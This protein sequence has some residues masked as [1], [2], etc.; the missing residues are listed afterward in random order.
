M[1]TP[2]LLTTGAKKTTDHKHINLTPSF[3][4]SAAILKRYALFRDDAALTSQKRA[5]L[6]PFMFTATE[7]N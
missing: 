5:Y 7:V 3:Q 6:D 4:A 2:Y 1:R